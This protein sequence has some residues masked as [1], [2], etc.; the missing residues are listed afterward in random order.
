MVVVPIVFLFSNPTLSAHV[1]ITINGTNIGKARGIVSTKLL[2]GAGHRDI[3][4]YLF[5]CHK[6]CIYF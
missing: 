2:R 1:D 6:E 3:I 5:T 4:F